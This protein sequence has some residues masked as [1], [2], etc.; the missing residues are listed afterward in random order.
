MNASGLHVRCGQVLGE[1]KFTKST[2]HKTVYAHSF[3]RQKS[4]FE[5]YLSQLTCVIARSLKDLMGRLLLAAAASARGCLD[6]NLGL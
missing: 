5:L 1:V 3:A 6:H 4:S 2:G